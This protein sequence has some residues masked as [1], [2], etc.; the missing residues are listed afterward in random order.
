[1]HGL[2]GLHIR[3]R[4]YPYSVKR[5]IPDENLRDTAVVFIALLLLLL[6]FIFV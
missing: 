4:E 2:F 5:E 1:M 6:H 3:M